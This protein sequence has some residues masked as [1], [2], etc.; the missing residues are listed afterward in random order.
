LNPGSPAPQASV[1]I[2]TRLRAPEND[3][4]TT[5]LNMRFSVAFAYVGDVLEYGFYKLRCPFPKPRRMDAASAI[6]TI[7]VLASATMAM[8]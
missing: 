5:N 4:D 7:T 3:Y 1:L 2:R 8:F 6:A